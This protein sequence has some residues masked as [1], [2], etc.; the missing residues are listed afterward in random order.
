MAAEPIRDWH[1]IAVE[2]LMTD[3]E[4]ALLSISYVFGW[5]DKQSVAWIAR[6]ARK[7]YDSVRQR[8]SAVNLSAS[9]SAYLDDKLERLRFK[10]NA[11]KG[12]TNGA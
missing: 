9:E 12:S 8:R 3:A 2:M 5:D 6:S 10:L 4:L 11:L 7:T 1:Q